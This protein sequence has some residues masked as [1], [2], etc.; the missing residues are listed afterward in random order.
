MFDNDKDD[1]NEGNNNNNKIN[2]KTSID[3][4]NYI[5]SSSL[6]ESFGSNKN[7]NNKKSEDIEYDEDEDE[8]VSTEEEKELTHEYE[9][10]D[11]DSEFAPTQ[12]IP[13]D[14]DGDD[15]AAQ[16]KQFGGGVGA[17][18]GSGSG[19]LM[20]SSSF[21]DKID[22]IFNNG[23]SNLNSSFLNNGENRIN[24]KQL[25]RLKS[26]LKR[27]EISFKELTVEKEIGQG[28]FGKVYKARWRGKSVA[29]KRITLIKFRDLSENEIFDKEVSIMSKLCH[30]TCVMFIG[31]CSLDGP[32]NR[33]I[34]MEYMEGGSLRRL[35]DEKSN[36]QLSPSLQLS[37]ARDIAEGMNYLHTN[38]KEG[39]IVHR[40]LTSSNILLNG[41]Y[42]VAKINDFGLSKEMKPG[43]SEMT[44]AMGSLAWMAPECF[45][46]ENYTEKVDVYSFAIILWELLTCRDPYNGMEPLRM[47]FLA[48][49]EDY[50]L[51]L[52]G[53]PAYWA[54]LISRC[55]NPIPS[56]RPSFQ[57]I[58][59]ILNQ[60]E[61][62]PSYQNLNLTC[63]S[64]NFFH[65]SSNNNIATSSSASTTST[66]TIKSNSIRESNINVQ[67]KSRNPSP[68]TSKNG[69]YAQ[70]INND[71]LSMQVETKN[72]TY[73]KNNSGDVN[74]SNDDFFKSSFTKK[75]FL[76]NN[77]NN[78][79]TNN[80]NNTN[81]NNTN[82]FNNNEIIKSLNCIAEQNSFLVSYQDSNIVKY[83]SLD[84]DSLTS[85]LQMDQ[86]VVCMKYQIINEKVFLVVAM[87]NNSISLFELKKTDFSSGDSCESTTLLPIKIFKCDER[88]KIK[89]ITWNGTHVITSSF[90]D[91]SIQIWDIEKSLA[92]ISRMDNSGVGILSIDSQ[93]HQPL[94]I[95]GDIDGKVKLWDIRNAHCFRTLT[96]SPSGGSIGVDS[97]LFRSPH[98]VR[99]PILLTGSS[100]DCKFKVWNMY[101]STCLNSFQSHS[102]DLLGIHRNQSSQQII[103][104]SSEGTIS[105]FNSSSGDGG[106]NGSVEFSKV[107]N[108]NSMMSNESLQSAQL[109]SKNRIIFSSKNKFYSILV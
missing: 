17:V 15:F 31:A 78:N 53:F 95:S 29:L 72:C 4:G 10:S 34:I 12:V 83:F 87:S 104:W 36:Y 23:G 21:N 68:S 71:S 16:D 106:D 54:E 5:N 51:P 20:S 67:T 85:T 59:Q 103:T 19:N 96:H 75:S 2:I 11:T 105:L 7:N 40:D 107:L 86:S 33:S 77:N 109:I 102:T 73:N 22:H 50:R 90:L 58:L 14:D 24:F 70:D 39:P 64:N 92:P 79:N 60:I 100:K 65:N 49:V 41:S 35:L 88:H 52:A 37:I 61:S 13:D 45:K 32:S 80:T 69:Y 76:S 66:T 47:A 108:V 82:S 93:S 18:G 43:P 91:S 30:P 25:V 81:Y 56:L 48:S 94:M 26:T 89:D 99:D 84:S 8:I 28:F 101:S 42:T 38:F 1:S 9:D 63:L 74:N 46:A 6:I 97:V 98:V 3:M 62:N 44:A 27:H 57:E 55:W